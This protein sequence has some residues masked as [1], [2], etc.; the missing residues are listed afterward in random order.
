MTEKQFPPNEFYEGYN[1]FMDLEEFNHHLLRMCT[2]EL[3]KD[4]FKEIIEF[5]PGWVM[6]VELANDIIDFI[7]TNHV[8]GVEHPT[9]NDFAKFLSEK[10]HDQ[11]DV[12][13]LIEI[14]RRFRDKQAPLKEWYG[15]DRRS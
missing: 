10:V 4:I 11:L 15:T 8:W 13:I 7:R 1:E 2:S 5:R 12:V 9:D 3:Q 6:N 14:M